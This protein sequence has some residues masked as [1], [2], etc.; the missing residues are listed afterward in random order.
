[1]M[2][3]YNR[4]RVLDALNEKLQ[5]LS[6]EVDTSEEQFAADLATWRETAPKNFAAAVAAYDPAVP[7]YFDTVSPISPPQKSQYTKHAS[8]Y[9]LEQVRAAIREVELMDGDTIPTGNAKGLIN[10]INLAL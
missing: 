7:G 8:K 3:T 1:M 6:Q 4:Q 2:A 9:R 10:L 5:I